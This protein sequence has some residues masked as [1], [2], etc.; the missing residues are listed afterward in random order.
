MLLVQINGDRNVFHHLY[1]LQVQAATRLKIIPATTHTHNS[2][3]RSVSENNIAFFSRPLCER[4]TSVF[5]PVTHRLTENGSLAAWKE[6][7]VWQLHHVKEHIVNRREAF[8]P[9]SP[10]KFPLI[11]Y[12]MMPSGHTRSGREVAAL[13]RRWRVC[14]PAA[15]SLDA[16]PLTATCRICIGSDPFIWS[17]DGLVNSFL[18][19]YLSQC[20]LS[21]QRS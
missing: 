4:H 18:L 17:G 5:L 14:R 10:V 16:E 15:L 11:T 3:T 21:G 6:L 7:K 1:F 9:G 19:W 2:P 12:G 8:N 13:L 20:G